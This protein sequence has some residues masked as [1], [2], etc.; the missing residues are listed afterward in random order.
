METFKVYFRIDGIPGSST[1][2]ITAPWDNDIRI[3]TTLLTKMKQR[4]QVLIQRLPEIKLT[5]FM[6][7]DNHVARDVIAP[8]III[9]ADNIHSLTQ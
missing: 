1:E 8:A 2:T 3:Y 6:L 4:L 7:S 9:N 5:I